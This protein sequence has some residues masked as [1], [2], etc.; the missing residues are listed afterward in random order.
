MARSLKQ[1]FADLPA[2]LQG[3]KWNGNDGVLRVRVHGRPAALP[4]RWIGRG[5]P[6][7]V[8]TAIQAISSQGATRQEHWPEGLVFAGSDLSPGA[9]EALRGRGANWADLLGRVRIVLPDGF[10]LLREVS[11]P[12]SPPEQARSLHWSPSA[13]S[14]AEAILARP[15]QPIRTTEVADIT[16]WSVPRVSKILASFDKPGWTERGGGERGPTAF[17]RLRDPKALLDAWSAHIAHEH[18]PSRQAHTTTRD[19]HEVSLKLRAAF[20]GAVKWMVSGW[21]A[22]DHLAPFMTTVPTLQLYIGSADF[23]D[24]LDEVLAHAG[25]IPVAEGGRIEIWPAEPHALRLKQR[26]GNW[27]LA[28]NPR[29]YADLMRL[30]GRGQEAA[31]HLKDI[32]MPPS[33]QENLN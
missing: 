29:V 2:D 5:W 9:I 26:H 12:P 18:R 25:V 7:D 19:I 1:A 4:V 31:D 6:Q 21:V 11:E 24:P 33:T 13:I 30:G 15:Q 17:R 14:V 32:W 20:D 3:I 16:N 27:T 10:A 22:L 8:D 23:G 28:S